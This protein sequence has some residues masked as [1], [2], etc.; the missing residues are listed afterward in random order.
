MRSLIRNF[1]ISVIVGGAFMGGV[2][3]LKRNY[4][5]LANK[6]SDVSEE[7]T[8]IQEVEESEDETVV[9]EETEELEDETVVIEETEESEDD[10]V[11]IEETEESSEIDV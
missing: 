1:F 5:L 9:I 11:V 8:I 2:I 3:L 4:D 7:N 10:T 6:N